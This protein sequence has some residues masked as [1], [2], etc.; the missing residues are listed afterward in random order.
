METLH[1][2]DVIDMQVIQ[3][4]AVA[5]IKQ[6][7][8]HE[9]QLPQPTGWRILVEPID[10]ETKTSGGILLPEDLKKSKEWNR[11]VGRVIR[12]GPDCYTHQDFKSGCWCQVGDWVLFNQ[13]TG[14]GAHIRDKAGEMV[15]LRFINDDAVLA[16][17]K[18]PRAF[19]IDM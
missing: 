10:I 19:E 7:E 17:A 12:M 4:A 5:E 18:D 11:Y 9:D 16:T 15:H 3:P 14:M 13:Y 1:S 8:Y 2:E 6:H